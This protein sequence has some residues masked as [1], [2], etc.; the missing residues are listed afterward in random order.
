MVIM[1]ISV[2]MLNM[3]LMVTMDI[4]V[5][6]II[7]QPFKYCT[8]KSEKSYGKGSKHIGKCKTIFNS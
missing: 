6:F 3:V 8:I 4:M 2:V 5:V 1:F 7:T